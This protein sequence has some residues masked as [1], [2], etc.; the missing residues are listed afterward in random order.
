M[1]WP[2]VSAVRDSNEGWFA[3]CSIPGAQTIRVLV[4]VPGIP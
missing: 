4:P 1:V 2:T 3:G